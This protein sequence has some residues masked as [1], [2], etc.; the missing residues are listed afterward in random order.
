MTDL[1]APDGKYVLHDGCT[2]HTFKGLQGLNPRWL[3]GDVVVM[4]GTLVRV[5]RVETFALL[6]EAVVGMPFGIIV[7][8]A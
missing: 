7:E 4:D 5:V 6:D 1:G 8:P 2:V 3:K